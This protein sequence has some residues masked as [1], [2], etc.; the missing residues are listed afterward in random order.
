M[1]PTMGGRRRAIRSG[2]R[3]AV[4][5][6]GS[7]EGPILR[8]TV[9]TINRSKIL[10]AILAGGF[11]ARW[12]HRGGRRYNRAFRARCAVASRAWLEGRSVREGAVY[13]V[14]RSSATSLGVA[15]VGSQIVHNRGEVQK[16]GVP[17]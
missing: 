17:V 5:S 12:R 11:C 14:Y 8:S 16:R 9:I 4:S 13:N 6:R 7:L 3:K 2:L 1:K 15:A 10:A